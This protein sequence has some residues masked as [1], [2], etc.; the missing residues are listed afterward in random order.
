MQVFLPIGALFLL[1]VIVM[2][3]GRRHWVFRG[4]VEGDIGYH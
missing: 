2:Y 1:P 4:K 3:S